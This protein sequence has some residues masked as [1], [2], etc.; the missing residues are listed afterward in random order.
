[1]VLIVNK[2]KWRN[3]FVIIKEFSNYKITYIFNYDHLSHVYNHCTSLSAK[4]AS[5]SSSMQGPSGLRPGSNAASASA[6]RVS[7]GA[8][9]GVAGGPQPGASNPSEGAQIIGCELYQNLQAFLENYL[10]QLLRVKAT[11][12]HLK[13]LT[14]QRF[15]SP[16]S[17]DSSIE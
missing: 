11:F 13:G 6:P 1:M 15:V 5:S 7:S 3:S 16:I 9:R 2:V 4:T 10:M 14:S 17:F 12:S 8:R